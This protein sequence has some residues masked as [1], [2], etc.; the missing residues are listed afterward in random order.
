M[1]TNSVGFYHLLMRKK[2]I[3]NASEGVRCGHCIKRE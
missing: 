2:H 1:G 3:P